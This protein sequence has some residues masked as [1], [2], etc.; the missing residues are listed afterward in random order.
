MPQI[1]KNAI[2]VNAEGLKAFSANVLL[3]SLKVGPNVE[4]IVHS[5]TNPE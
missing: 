5:K 2:L 1:K 4:G 3:V